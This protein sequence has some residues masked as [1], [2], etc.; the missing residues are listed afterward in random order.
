MCTVKQTAGKKLS[1]QFNISK[2]HSLFSGFVVV[3]VVGGGG[4]GDSAVYVCITFKK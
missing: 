4:G 2:V 3:V 1:N